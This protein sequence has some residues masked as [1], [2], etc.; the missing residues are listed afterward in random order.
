MKIK[1]QQKLQIVNVLKIH[2]GRTLKEKEVLPILLIEP[3][4]SHKI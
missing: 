3:K 2:Q 1:L 4:I